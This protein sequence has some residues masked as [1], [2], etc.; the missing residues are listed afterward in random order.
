MQQFNNLCDKV[1]KPRAI[2]F[3]ILTTAFLF[4]VISIVSRKCLSS[5]DVPGWFYVCLLLLSGIP[6]AIYY[7]YLEFVY[8]EKEKLRLM[9]QAANYKKDKKEVDIQTANDIIKANLKVVIPK[10]TELDKLE[11]RVQKSYSP[12]LIRKYLKKSDEL[13]YLFFEIR[14]CS[15]FL[16][17]NGMNV[18][19]FK[20]RDTE[21]EMGHVNIK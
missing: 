21:E 5:N 20:L 13:N 4:V 15:E 14:C 19:Y 18:N 6:C 12:F 1:G 16:K 8:Y 9:N 10:K 11:K 3:L 17:T 2:I 7:F